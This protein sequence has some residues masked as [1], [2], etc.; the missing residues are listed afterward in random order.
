ML[1]QSGSN[2]LKDLHSVSC[3]NGLGF[4]QLLL[5]EM[6]EWSLM[7]RSTT[8]ADFTISLADTRNMSMSVAM[9]RQWV[10]VHPDWW[11]IQIGG[12]SGGDW[13]LVGWHSHR[14]TLS[15]V[16]SW[17]DL[18]QSGCK[19]S[20]YIQSVFELGGRQIQPTKVVAGIDGEETS[21]Q[22]HSAEVGVELMWTLLPLSL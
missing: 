7:P 15:H 8:V 10:V 13:C 18:N 12:W 22:R 9:V 17:W 6:A 1:S 5:R 4:C 16:S 2:F 11:C 20:K 19:W 21:S 3:G 14:H